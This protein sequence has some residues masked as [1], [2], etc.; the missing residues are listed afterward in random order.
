VFS[1]DTRKGFLSWFKEGVVLRSEGLRLLLEEKAPW[2]PQALKRSIFMVFSFLQFLIDAEIYFV[3]FLWQS[4]KGLVWVC[5]YRG[6][7]V[8]ASFRM[9]KKI[10][11]LHCLVGLNVKSVIMKN[12]I[13]NYK[14]LHVI[15][16][17]IY[18]YIY[19]VEFMILAKYKNI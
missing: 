12:S 13:D 7:E 9:N 15:Y 16:I 11:Y 2:Q 17:Y 19:K 10:S 6:G 5:L 18:I 1:W 4:I 3:S 8:G 14:N